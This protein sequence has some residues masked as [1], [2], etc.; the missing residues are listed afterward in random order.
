MAK[1]KAA[2]SRPRRQQKAARLERKLVRPSLECRR[3][4]E[5]IRLEQPIML[6]IPTGSQRRRLNCDA[7]QPSAARPKQHFS[8]SLGP[9]Q[10]CPDC[11]IGS[12]SLT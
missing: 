10:P 5:V 9:M 2:R 8:S 11:R 6:E 3:Q 7:H 12:Y 1:T 4:C